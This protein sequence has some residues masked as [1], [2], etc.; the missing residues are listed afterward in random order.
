MVDAR[1]TKVGEKLVFSKY[2]DSYI[3][4]VI[5]YTGNLSCCGLVLTV[6]SVTNN[7]Y[8]RW[9]E[10]EVLRMFNGI[11]LDYCLPYNKE[12]PIIFMTRKVK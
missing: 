7:L 1:Y 5:E 6:V 10:G 2:G 3:L 9:E 8:Y 4:E 12:D 11:G